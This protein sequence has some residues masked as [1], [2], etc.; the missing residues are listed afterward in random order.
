MQEPTWIITF[1]DEELP[2]VVSF[3]DLYAIRNN[4]NSAL[5]LWDYNSYRVDIKDKYFC[6]NG[7]K[8]IYIQEMETPEFVYLRRNIRNIYENST[9]SDTNTFYILGMQENSNTLVLNISSDGS[10]WAW[11]THK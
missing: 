10:N 1:K 9:N 3:K 11:K 2:K 8:K 4:I 5:L 6:V 7:G